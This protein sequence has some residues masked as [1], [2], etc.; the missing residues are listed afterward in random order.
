M[1]QV[2]CVADL[3]VDQN[4]PRSENANRRAVSNIFRHAP[5]FLS[6]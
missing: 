1:G 3:Q 6:F 5:D 2:E 4:A